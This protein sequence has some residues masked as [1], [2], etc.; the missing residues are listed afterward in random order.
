[1][2]AAQEQHEASAPSFKEPPLPSPHTIL[3]GVSGTIYTHTTEPLKEVVI[4]TH[5]AKKLASELR[6]LF[7]NHAA[8]L[9]QPGAH[10]I[11]LPVGSN[12]I[13]SRFRVKPGA[14]L[15]L[16]PNDLFLFL[17]GEGVL[18]YSLPK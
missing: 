5:R 1:M 8:E 16:P 4:L 2:S 10:L 6:M 11:I 3:L 12:L 9:V 7:V 13:R 14:T 18:R 17:S 15:L